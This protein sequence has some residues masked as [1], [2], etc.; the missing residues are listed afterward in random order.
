MNSKPTLHGYWRSGCSWRLRIVL[1][2]KGIEYEQ[3]YVHLV[4]G[5]QKSPEHCEMN[6]AGMVPVLEVNGLTLTESMPI[7]E[8]LEEAFPDSKK[9]LPADPKDKFEVR[10]L[11]E[12]INSGTQPIQNLG[13]L[14]KVEEFGGDKVAWGK[15][16]I[17]KGLGVFELF[18]AKTKGK[19]CFGDELTLADAFLIP[20]LYNAGRFGVEV[21][22]LF[23]NIWEISQTLNQIPEFDKAAADNQEDANQ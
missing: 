13:I 11:C 15:S 23:P 14:K 5:E 16:I 8:Y 12:I 19:Y 17:E 20:Q 2:L 18:L 1:N 22:K 7:C 6:P 4:K 3:K 9:L 21:E 10:R